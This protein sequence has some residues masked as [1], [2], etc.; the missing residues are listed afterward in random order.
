MTTTKPA[1][2]ATALIDLLADYGV[3]TIFGIP[4]VHTLEFYRHLSNSALTHVVTRHEQGAAF[5]AALIAPGSR[6]YN[7][8]FWQVATPSIH[9]AIGALLFAAEIRLALRAYHRIIPEPVPAPQ[10]ASTGA[11]KRH[12]R[13]VVA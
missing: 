4:G 3:D 11:P 6:T 13:E 7:P 12:L 5:T 8:T 1:N 2:V 9:Q 10:S